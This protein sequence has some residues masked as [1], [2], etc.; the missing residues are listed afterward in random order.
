[1]QAGLQGESGGPSMLLQVT[2][3]NEHCSLLLQ[4]TSAS[5]DH[6][7]TAQLLAA[8]HGV[9]GHTRGHCW[10]RQLSQP[11]DATACSF[12]LL[13]TTRHMHG[14]CSVGFDSSCHAWPWL[15]LHASRLS[16]MPTP[17]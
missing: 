9:H 17:R 12:V 5:L 13:N 3:A 4:L 1:M 11:R 8:W 14:G 6:E 16:S 7:P 15:L 2:R 10:A